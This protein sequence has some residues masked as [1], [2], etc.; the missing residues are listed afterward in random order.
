MYYRISKT[1]TAY[2]SVLDYKYRPAAFALKSWWQMCKYFEVVKHQANAVEED[3]D[4]SEN[5]EDKHSAEVSEDWQY[6]TK[7]NPYEPR[8]GYAVARRLRYAV[9]LP[10]GKRLPNR[11]LLEVP[12]QV[13]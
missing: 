7:S 12:E 8:S 3:S 9:P 1:G 13:K 2:S 5:E 6:D 11:D 10:T 4:D